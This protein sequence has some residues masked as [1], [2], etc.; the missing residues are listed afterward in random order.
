MNNRL[1]YKIDRSLLQMEANVRENRN[2]TLKVEDFW[3]M[4]CGNK[5]A[6]WDS[7]SHIEDCVSY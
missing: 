7:L 5:I 3:S 6:G 4:L 1:S 2:E